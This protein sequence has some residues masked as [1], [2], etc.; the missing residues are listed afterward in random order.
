MKAGNC[1]ASVTTSQNAPCCQTGPWV[2]GVCQPDGTIFKTR[3]VSLL[4]P[5]T[6]ASGMQEPCCYTSD[7]T[8]EV[9]AKCNSTTATVAQVRTK[10]GNC[11]ASVFTTQNAPC[12]PDETFTTFNSSV[13]NS[14]IYAGSFIGG[15][16][17]LGAG[18]GLLIH[19]LR[20]KKLN[21]SIV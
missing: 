1:E 5:N 19:K 20:K 15:L 4:C 8:N 7:W 9:N 12:K 14:A 21:P 18:V 2:S 13:S 17:F 16:L 6:E 11:D 10:A 3:S